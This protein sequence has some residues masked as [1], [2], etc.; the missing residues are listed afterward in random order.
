LVISGLVKLGYGNLLL[1]GSFLRAI[2]L[3]H[4]GDSVSSNSLHQTR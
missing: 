2:I 3:P 4:S 1:R